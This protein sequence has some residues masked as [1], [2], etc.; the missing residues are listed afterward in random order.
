MSEVSQALYAVRGALVL[1]RK[2]LARLTWYF[3]GNTATSATAWGVFSRS[4]L[5]SSSATGFQPKLALRAMQS[6]VAT[7]GDRHFVGVIRETKEGFVY[8]LGTEA[9]VVTHIVAWLPISGDD[10]TVATITF[11]T[12]AVP[13]SAQLVGLT[14][15]APVPLP[16][17]S[18]GQWTMQ[19]SAVPVIVA[20]SA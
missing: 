13:L 3:Y 2:G 12:A 7:M 11:P 4:G 19:V 17:A 14:S 6:L 1:A 15:V 18:Q 9:G 16:V 10:N 8:Q 5:V 20:I